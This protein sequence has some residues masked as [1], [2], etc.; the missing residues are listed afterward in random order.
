[1]SINRLVR[2]GFICRK[3]NRDYRKFPVRL[4]LPDTA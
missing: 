3:H 4:V 1:M 2:V